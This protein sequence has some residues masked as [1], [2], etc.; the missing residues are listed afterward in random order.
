MGR[1]LFFIPVIAVLV[2]VA[3]AL[4]SVL[5]SASGTLVVEAMSSGRYSPS[6]QLHVV[7]SVGSSTGTTPFNFTLP[8]AE[9]TVVYGPINWYVTPP[10]RSLFVPN[11]K[12]T[13]ANALYVPITRAITV[14][15]GGFNSTFVTAMHGVTPVVWMNRGD[16]VVVVEV[17]T[18]G[19]IP[20]NPSQNYTTV[21]PYSGT[22][23]FDILGTN[24]AGAVRSL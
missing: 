1:L 20:L 24:F 3:F 5:F 22:F 15:N 2:L 10:S 6:V 19:R 23:N 13:Y 4:V 21:F 18:M 14:T 7:V 8:Q 16:A 9:Y 12:T 11:G 17:D